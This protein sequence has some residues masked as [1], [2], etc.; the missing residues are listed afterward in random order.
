MDKKITK[1]VNTIGKVNKQEYE[2]LY[3]YSIEDNDNFWAKQGEK[4]EWIKKF[5]KIKDFTYS[6]KM[7][8]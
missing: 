4:I 6:K 3:R 1:F 2:D 8:T 5:S 7:S